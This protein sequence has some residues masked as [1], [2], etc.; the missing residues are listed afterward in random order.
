M[1]RIDASNNATLLKQAFE[2]KLKEDSRTRDIYQDFQGTFADNKKMLPNGIVTVKR[3]SGGTY[4]ANMGLIRDLAGSGVTGRDIQLGQEVDQV[5][6]EMQVYSND[7]SQAINTEQY[8]IDAHTKSAYS[9]LSWV[10]PQ[11]ALWHKEIEGKYIREALLERYSGNLTVAPTSQTKRWNE[12]VLVKNVAFSAQPTYDSTNATYESNISTA[13]GTGGA[14]ADWDVLYLNAIIEWVTGVKSIEAMDN[15]RYVVTVPSRQAIRL[16]D[17]SASDSITGIY[18]DSNLQEASNN[19][20]KQYLGTYG[21]VLDLYSDPRAPVVG[22]VAGDL[23]AYYKGAGTDDD[24]ASA[25]GTLYDVSFVHGKGSVVKAVHE[26]VHFEAEDQ[27]YEK[28]KG[29]GAFQGYGY[30]RLVFDDVGSE[31]D[32]SQVNNNSVALFARRTAITS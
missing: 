3:L 5:L 1:L 19:S 7:V 28:I 8:G 9:V 27:N 24:R 4:N 18:K 31:T 13:L 21:D 10:E 11:L 23:T 15:G 25:A 14:S 6:K 22:D 20:W 17:P 2:A 26:D 32:T 30:N 29:I 16:M 12:N